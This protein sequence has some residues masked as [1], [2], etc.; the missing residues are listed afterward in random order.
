MSS[1]SPVGS[2]IDWMNTHFYLKYTPPPTLFTAHI[3][4]IVVLRVTSDDI[5]SF[6]DLGRLSPFN[7]GPVG[8]CPAES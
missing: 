8:K 2:G 4:R 5:V 6:S 1:G 3:T 7:V